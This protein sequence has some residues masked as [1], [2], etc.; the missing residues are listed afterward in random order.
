MK[1][2]KGKLEEFLKMNALPT[3]D[4][5]R[6][7]GWVR[8]LQLYSRVVSG[9]PLVMTTKNQSATI[10]HV[11]LSVRVADKMF[12]NE[13]WFRVDWKISDKNGRTG[14]LF[15]INQQSLFLS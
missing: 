9:S 5:T 4:E 8:F 15:V 11:T 6:V 14:T 7:D 13:V 3:L 10:T 2:L 1:Y 12:E